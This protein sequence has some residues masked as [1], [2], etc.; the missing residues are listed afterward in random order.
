MYLLSG[1][2]MFPIVINLPIEEEYSRINC[3]PSALYNELA[4]MK[5]EKK[6]ELSHHVCSL[7]SHERLNVL[8]S[9]TKT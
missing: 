5:A 4:N 6:E 1:A 3:S 8:D 9:C 7:P 2:D